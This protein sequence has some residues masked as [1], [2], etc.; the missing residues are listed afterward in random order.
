MT[1]TSTGPAVAS[2]VQTLYRTSCGSIRDGAWDWVPL[3]QVKSRLV[4]EEACH[5]GDESEPL[6]Q[7]PSLPMTLTLSL[8]L[9]L[10]LTLN[11]TETLGSP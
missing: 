5:P 6:S 8:T 11:L 1:E 2:G 4:W 9:R 3:S 7:P 10:Y